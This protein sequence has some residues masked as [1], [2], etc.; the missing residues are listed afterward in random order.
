MKAFDVFRRQN[1]ELGVFEYST[2]FGFYQ[3]EPA[4]VG[5][6]YSSFLTSIARYYVGPDLTLKKSEIGLTD[7]K[8]NPHAMDRETFNR[9]TE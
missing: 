2:Q 6:I 7:P 5:D 8:T 1:G 4:Q 3:I 9:S